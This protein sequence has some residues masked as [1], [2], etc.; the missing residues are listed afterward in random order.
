MNK[1][2]Y[3]YSQKRKIHSCKHRHTQKEKKRPKD[4]TNN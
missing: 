1:G 4:V 2:A 3:T